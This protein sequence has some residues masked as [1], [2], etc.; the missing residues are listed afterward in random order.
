MNFKFSLKDF[1]N[2]F[3]YFCDN[4]A[5]FILSIYLWFKFLNFSV[6]FFMVF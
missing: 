1:L 3:Q 2:K 5:I 4:F 6:Y